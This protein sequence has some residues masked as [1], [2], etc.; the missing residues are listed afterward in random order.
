MSSKSYISKENS[1]SNVLS[2]GGVYTGASVDVSDYTGVRVSVYSDQSSASGGLSLQFSHDRVNWDFIGATATVSAGVSKV[3]ASDVIS[4]YFRVVY[5]NGGTTQGTFRLQSLIT[6]DDS[7][8]TSTSQSGGVNS[9]STSNYLQEVSAG[10]ISGVMSVHKFG[11]TVDVSSFPSTVWFTGGLYTWPTM[12]ATMAIVSDSAAD[13]TGGGTGATQ[14][15]VQG[16]DVNYAN[17]SEY[18]TLQGTTPVSTVNSYLRLNRCVV[19]EAGSSGQNVG[20]ITVTH[21]GNTLA[22]IEAGVCQT[23]LAIY[24]VPTGTDAYIYD[25][26]IGTAGGNNLQSTIM[27]FVRPLG[28]VF[29]SKQEYLFEANGSSASHR[30]FTIP[31]KVPSYSDIEWRVMTGNSGMECAISFDMT[32]VDR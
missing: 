18:V 31:Y 28:Q 30:Q 12:A 6:N 32:L 8:T 2:S 13:A 27:M 16:L 4:Q 25:A 3:L 7:V 22:T 14:V 21:S 26:T 17:S 10:N 15:Y 24:T 5:T 11:R 20:D 29:Q 23:Q 1:T 9:Y 19:T